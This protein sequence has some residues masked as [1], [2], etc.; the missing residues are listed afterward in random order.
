MKRI[1]G[2]FC[3]AIVVS[4]LIFYLTYNGS[5]TLETTRVVSSSTVLPEG[6]SVSAMQT[7][8]NTSSTKDKATKKKD[9]VCSCCGK[10]LEMVKQRRKEF[11]QWAQDTI[12]RHGYEEGM[13]QVTARSPVLAKRMQQILEKEKNDP[14]SSISQQN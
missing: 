8:S 9:D 6:K 1:F 12:A 13:K 5:S 10:S 4:G 3:I 7:T 14:P 11:E 2:I